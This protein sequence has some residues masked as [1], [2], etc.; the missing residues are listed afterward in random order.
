MNPLNNLIRKSRIILSNI[1]LKL[2]LQ[3]FLEIFLFP[4]FYLYNLCLNLNIINFNDKKFPTERDY[5]ESNF[6]IIGLHD[7]LGYPGIRKKSLPNGVEFYCGRDNIINQISSSKNTTK[8]KF[9]LNLSGNHTLNEI[10]DSLDEV[11]Y[12]DNRGYDFN[13]YTNILLKT[14]TEND[15]PIIVLMNSSVAGVFYDGWLDDY[16]SIIKNDPSV[17]LLGISAGSYYPGL[18]K[19]RFSPH[20]QSYFL[21]STQ[22]IFSKILN[23]NN[24]HFPGSYEKNKYR[25]IQEGEIELSRQILKYGYSIVIVFNGEIKKFSLKNRYSNNY[26]QWPFRYGDIRVSE[27]NFD[28]INTLS[29]IP[30]IKIQD[31]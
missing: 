22:E 3:I 1:S 5:A 9:I 12:T 14:F 10:D 31:V 15:N 30:K 26:K 24:N 29:K 7:W 18:L 8:Y 19:N 21:L 4:L 13:G 16:C 23:N 11:Y 2:L 20:I 6:A 28:L 17:G 25:L 27:K